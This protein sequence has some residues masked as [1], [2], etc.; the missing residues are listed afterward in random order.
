MNSPKWIRPGWYY[1]VVSGSRTI[2]GDCVVVEM[3][4]L[5]PPYEG[6]VVDYR[7]DVGNHAKASRQLPPLCR[8][9]GVPLPHDTSEFHG[10]HVFVRIGVKQGRANVPKGFKP[11]P[12]R[13]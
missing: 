13:T 10:R 4:L 7:I 6:I 5:A 11:V 9:C 2:S 8:A 1:A 12:D 3:T